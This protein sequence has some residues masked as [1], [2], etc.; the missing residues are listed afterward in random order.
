MGTGFD[1]MSAASHHIAADIAPPLRRN[2]MM[3][4]GL[5]TLAGFTHDPHEW[6]HYQLPDAHAYPFIADGA[7]AP[8]LMK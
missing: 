5:M 8:A 2:R 7:F 1:E 4:L 6:W 3:L